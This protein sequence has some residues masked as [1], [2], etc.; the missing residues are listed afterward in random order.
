MTLN[1]TNYELIKEL[2]INATSDHMTPTPARRYIYAGV[3]WPG[4]RAG[5]AIIV[6]M[7]DRPHLDSHDVCVLAEFESYSTR[8]LVRQMKKSK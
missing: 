5:F 2:R 4:K 3:A 7:D 8:E 6:L 1:Q